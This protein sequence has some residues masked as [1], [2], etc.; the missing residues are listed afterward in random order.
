L[1]V[2]NT[3]AI[4]IGFDPSIQDVSLGDPAAVEVFITGL[5]DYSP[6]SLSA[7]D[8]EITYDPSI[9]SMT[10]VIFGDPILGDQLDLFGLGGNPQGVFNIAP[11]VENIFEI[12]FDFPGDLE[13]FQAS[14]FTLATL[15]FDTISPGSSLLSIYIY[16]ISDA[17][18]YSLYGDTETGV[19]NVTSTAPIPEPATL[20][21]LGSG[22]AG[23]GIVRRFRK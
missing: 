3:H 9:L 22:M 5:G 10:T 8:L 21:L 14:T 12:S 1:I 11:G 17:S 2:A 20:L 15:I 7:F 19:I 23:I 16:A 4:T 13:A 18:G 6:P